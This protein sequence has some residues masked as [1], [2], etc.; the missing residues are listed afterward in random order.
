MIE[1]CLFSLARSLGDKHSR[2]ITECRGEIIKFKNVRL[3]L[4]TSCLS[5]IVFGVGKKVRVVTK[6]LKLVIKRSKGEIK[7]SLLLERKAMTN[8]VSVLKSRDIKLC[9]C[10]QVVKSRD[11]TLP[12]KVH[13]VKA[14]VV[15]YECES[16][17]RKNAGH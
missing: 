10:G 16:W 3:Q 8:L 12:I 7:R 6:R 15:M 13:M 17:T 11:I 5:R 2:S 1:R 9:S 4:V 14:M